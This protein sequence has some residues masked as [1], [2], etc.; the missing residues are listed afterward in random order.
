MPFADEAAFDK[1]FYAVVVD[2]VEKI[3]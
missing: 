2:P 3:F 1:Y